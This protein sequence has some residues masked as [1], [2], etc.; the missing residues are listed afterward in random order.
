MLKEKCLE[1][2]PHLTK[3]PITE[4]LIDIRVKLPSDF[5]V[6][7]LDIHGKII[8]EYPTRH[9]LSSFGGKFG[10]KDG[11]PLSDISEIKKEGFRYTSHDKLYV[12]QSRL[13]GFTL[14]R[15]KPY[16]TWALL[17]SEGH[18]LWSLYKEITNPIIVRVALRY[19]N[20]ITIPLPITDFGA[21]FTAPPIIPDKLPQGIISYFNRTVI[22]EPNIG[23]NAIVT[24]SMEPLSQPDTVPI[25]FDIDVYK[26]K[27]SGFDENELWETLEKI[28]DF[29]N[30][31]FY[32]SITAKQLEELK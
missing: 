23:A 15:L 28:R 17:K 4:A 19:I 3:A 14:S 1:E 5:D 22:H 25:M 16:E 8:K 27:S 13:D 31:I 21:F 30:K 26:I 6:N 9:E 24:N 10:V 12:F 2:Y 29:K 11:Q 18:K 20:R 32:N 7:R